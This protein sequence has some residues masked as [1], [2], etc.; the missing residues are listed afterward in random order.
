MKFRD[1]SVGFLDPF[2]DEPAS[3]GWEVEWGSAHRAG[4]VPRGTGP[5]PPVHTLGVELVVTRER[6][7][8]SVI[9]GGETY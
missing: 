3:I 1:K 5:L 9:Q 2:D 8:V 7:S 4:G 6:T